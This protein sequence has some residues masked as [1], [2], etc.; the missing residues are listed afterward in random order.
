MNNL[1]KISRGDARLLQI[2]GWIFTLSL[3]VP[4]LIRIC[5]NFNYYLVVILGFALAFSIIFQ[6]GNFKL[7]NIWYENNFIQFCNVYN[8][9]SVIIEEFDKILMTILFRNEYKLYLRNG[10]TYKFRINPAENL[11]LW[12]KSDEQ[13]CAR[14]LT[15]KLRGEQN[16]Y[17][18]SVK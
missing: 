7:W 1:I 11:K 12:L 6:K 18:S 16:R 5:L 10:K 8:S 4:I 15:N 9:E 14:E 13:Y 2:I 17:Y 3:L